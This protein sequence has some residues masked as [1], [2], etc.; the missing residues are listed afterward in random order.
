ML[1]PQELAEQLDGLDI[2]IHSSDELE[3]ES[4]TQDGFSW[5]LLLAGLLVVL[6]LGEQV[7][8]YS[9]SYHPKGGEVA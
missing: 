6:L 5:S 3:Y 4:T 9:A 8:A 7:L 1:Q 2:E